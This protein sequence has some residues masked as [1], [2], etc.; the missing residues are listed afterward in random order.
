[1]IIIYFLDKYLND[2]W[3]YSLTTGEWSHLS[4]E[5]VENKRSLYDDDPYPGS[6][7]Y[8]SIWFDDKTK[9][10]YL[11]GGFGCDSSP[12]CGL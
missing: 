3:Q 10:V 8:S 7:G 2:L 1:M 11:F 4:G 6:R 9:K 5:T 12:V